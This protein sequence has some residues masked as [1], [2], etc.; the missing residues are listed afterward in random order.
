MSK[1]T[2]RC[3][4]GDTHFLSSIERYLLL[5]DRIHTTELQSSRFQ[6]PARQALVM[7]LGPSSR[8]E[9]SQILCEP[10]AFAALML[11]HALRANLRANCTASQGLPVAVH[12][13]FL[14]SFCLSTALDYNLTRYLG[15]DNVEGL[16]CRNLSGQ[17]LHEDLFGSKVVVPDTAAQQSTLGTSL[18]LLW[19][20]SSWY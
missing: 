14:V 13:V 18:C 19:G 3:D 7:A 20:L 16:P 8:G 5:V 4:L 15:I 10:T 1:S 6:V 17:G 12:V 2:P 9:L 11:F